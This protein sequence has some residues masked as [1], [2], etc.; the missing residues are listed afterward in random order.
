MPQSLA[1]LE[2]VRVDYCWEK[3]I[4]EDAGLNYGR[5]EGVHYFK[6]TYL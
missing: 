6:K 3:H 2:K 4:R 5:K 1:H